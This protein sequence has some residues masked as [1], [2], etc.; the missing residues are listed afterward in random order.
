[1]Y[2]LFL[3]FFLVF[4]LCENVLA[5]E[6]LYPVYFLLGTMLFASYIAER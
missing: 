4:V 5:T 1:L 6:K 3:C 2:R